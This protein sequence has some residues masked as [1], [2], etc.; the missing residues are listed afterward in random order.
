MKKRPRGQAIPREAE[1]EMP[2]V[3]WMEEVPAGP[4]CKHGEVHG[5]DR[6]GTTVRD[7]GHTTVNGRGLVARLREKQ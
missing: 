6:C 4:R 1:P 5:C 2:S 3:G 7:A